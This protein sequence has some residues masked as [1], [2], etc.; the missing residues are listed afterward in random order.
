MASNKPE[1]VGVFS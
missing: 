1:H